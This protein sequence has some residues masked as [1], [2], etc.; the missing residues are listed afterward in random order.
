MN[1]HIHQN[2]KL[3]LQR[4]PLCPACISKCWILTSQEGK[5][6]FYLLSMHEFMILE[7][8][9]T[10]TLSLLSYLVNTGEYRWA[11][12]CHIHLITLTFWKMRN[13]CWQKLYHC[14]ILSLMFSKAV[15]RAGCV[16]EKHHHFSQAGV[17]RS[18]R[19]RHLQEPDGSGLYQVRDGC[20]GN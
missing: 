18:Q 14:R 2:V 13:I 1:K 15:G 10:D 12:C 4:F 7:G 16:A 6:A 9:N 8:V 5:Y 3:F 17:H 20:G 19:H 11:C